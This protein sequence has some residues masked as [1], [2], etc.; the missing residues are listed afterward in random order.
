MTKLGKYDI[1]AKLGAGAMG[2]V[3]K[4]FDP[5]LKRY[6]A[7]KVIAQQYMLD[8]TAQLRFIREAQSAAALTH[9]NI[10]TVYD[11]GEDGGC[12]YYSMEF[13]DGE[14][15]S[16]ILERT[17]PLTV[18][19]ALQMLTPLASALDAAHGIGLVHRD[20]KPSNILVG[21]GV[22]KIADFGIAFLPGSTLT[23]T[24]NWIG[25]VP[26]MAPELWQGKR[27]DRASDLYAFAVMACQMLGGRL[28][29]EITSTA[30]AVTKHC[31]TQPDLSAVDLLLRPAIARGLAKKPADRFGNCSEFV[32]AMRPKEKPVPQRPRGLVLAAV[33]LA[34]FVGSAIFFTS[35][36]SATA[37]SSATPPAGIVSARRAA[38]DAFA[39]LGPGPEKGGSVSKFLAKHKDAMASL[40]AN[41]QYLAQHD[42]NS[43]RQADGYYYQGIRSMM[44]TMADCERRDVGKA[45]ID[46]E[47][48]CQQL[49]QCQ[50][51]GT[52]AQQR[53]AT[54][55]AHAAWRFINDAK[56]PIGSDL[57]VDLSAI[58]GD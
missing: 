18:E 1:V 17:G 53:N 49:R 3:F 51:L 42:A 23:G 14:D 10:V 33:A 11:V 48:C 7:I 9:P 15:L 41:G 56:T 4:G 46:L 39:E 30:D 43:K 25:T 20:I 24:G 8:Q 12:F 21:N 5:V 37:G 45:Q 52:S 26:Y 28:P 31:F 40:G 58:S 16:A 57:M 55:C 32:K 27:A 6:A 13:V 44:L 29:F 50:K 34:G 19:A 22:A 38:E 36:H 2:V 35:T 54:S 47:A